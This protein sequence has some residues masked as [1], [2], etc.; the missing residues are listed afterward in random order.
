MCCNMKETFED[1]CNQKFGKLIA[2]YCNIKYTGYKTKRKRKIWTC[3]CECGNYTNVDYYNLINGHTTSCGCNKN[4]RFQLRADK[5][6]I[7][8]KF[9]K[10]TDLERIENK[11]DIWKCKCDCGSILSIKGSNLKNGNTQSCGCLQKEKIA[12]ANRKDISGQRFGKLIALY[13][14]GEKNKQRIW[15]C[16]CDCGGIVRVKASNLIRGITTSCGCIRSK[17][18]MKI[19]LLLQENNILFIPQ[20]KVKN[21]RYSDS[22]RQPSFDFGIIDKEENLLY[23]IEYDGTIHYDVHVGGWNTVEYRKNVK[24]KDDLKNQ[25][26]INNNIPLIRIP[27]WRYDDLCIE[28][29]QLNTTKYLIQSSDIEEQQED[30]IES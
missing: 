22:N 17:G 10:L 14:C 15:F 27:Y 11:A 12:K 19:N 26:C 20:Y 8:Q 25:F 29:L 23:L 2:L 1:I 21:F 9:G 28:D 3:K 5:D 13:D 16:K 7:G 4:G 24:K 30:F 6:M 18:E